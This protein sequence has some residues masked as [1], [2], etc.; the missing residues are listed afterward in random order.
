[1]IAGLQSSGEHSAASAASTLLGFSEAL[2]FGF[3]E[4][5]LLL[6]FFF[7]CAA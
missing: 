4:Y 6:Y 3:F 2:I 7:P 5:D 1:M